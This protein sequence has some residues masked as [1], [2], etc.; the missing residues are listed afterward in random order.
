MSLSSSSSSVEETDNDEEEI[1]NNGEFNWSDVDSEEMY[2]D[3]N[4]MKKKLLY[5]IQK[6]KE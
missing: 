6:M 5:S 1:E 2:N 3:E 4:Q